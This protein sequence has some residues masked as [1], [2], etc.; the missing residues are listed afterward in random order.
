V[1]AVK[2]QDKSRKGQ[3]SDV[4]WLKYEYYIFKR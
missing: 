4:R 2:K 1:Y 3:M